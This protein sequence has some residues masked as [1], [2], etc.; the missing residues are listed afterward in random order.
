MYFQWTSEG[1]LIS[2]LG[3]RFYFFVV[4]M[5]R[6][7]WIGRQVVQASLPSQEQSISSSCPL[8]WPLD[9]RVPLDSVSICLKRILSSDQLTE[10][11]C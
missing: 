5:S 8:E 10:S 9:L 11:R 1:V 2:I 6:I 4:G 7:C 3:I